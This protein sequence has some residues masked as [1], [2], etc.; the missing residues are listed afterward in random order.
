MTEDEIN[1]LVNVYDHSTKKFN[2]TS[3]MFK[4]NFL[5]VIYLT[6]IIAGDFNA[7]GS[8]VSKKNLKSLKLRF[9][10]Y[11]NNFTNIEP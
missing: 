11:E 3:C 9:V 2:T 10:F 7:E 1:E 5:L 6:G 8:Y 4:K